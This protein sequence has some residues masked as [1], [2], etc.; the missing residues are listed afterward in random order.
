[1]TSSTPKQ[2]LILIHSLLTPP[3]LPLHPP[4]RLLPWESNTVVYRFLGSD[5]CMY[6]F[7]DTMKKQLSN[8]HVK[9]E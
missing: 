9:V 3:S 1:M 4:V 2:L 8:G 7:I 5:K 6:P